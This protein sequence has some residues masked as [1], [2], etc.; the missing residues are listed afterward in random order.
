[1]PLRSGKGRTEH[2]NQPGNRCILFVTDQLFALP[3]ISTFRCRHPGPGPSS[4]FMQRL[5]GKILTV[6]V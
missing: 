3:L 1:M 5:R 4:I 2:G 6:W